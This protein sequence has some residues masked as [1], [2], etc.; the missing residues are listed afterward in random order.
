MDAIITDLV[1]QFERGGLTGVS[2]FRVS[3]HSPRRSTPNP[4]AH[5]TETRVRER[6]V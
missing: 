2:G 3:R 6:E 1:N 4:S 5:R